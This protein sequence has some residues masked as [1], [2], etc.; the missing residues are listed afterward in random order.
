LDDDFIERKNQTT[1]IHQHRDDIL[2]VLNEI[3][4]L[5]NTSVY[6]IAYLQFR[7]LIP[8]IDHAITQSRSAN[9]ANMRFD[10]KGTIDVELF[11]ERTPRPYRDYIEYEK[12][13]SFQIL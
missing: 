8:V 12:I 3:E 13:E 10:V 4:Q 11:Y 9:H 5:R 7:E 1:I 2:M 6:P